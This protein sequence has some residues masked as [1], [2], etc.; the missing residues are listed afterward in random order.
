[1]SAYASAAPPPR[2][3]RWWPRVLAIVLALVA[4]LALALVGAAWWLL[5][6]SGGAQFL[7]ARAGTILGPGA[8]V[9]GV[10][11]RIGG[12]VKIRTIEID[13]PDLYVHVDDLVLDTAPLAALHGMLDVRRLTARE[14]EVRTAPSAKKAQP[15]AIPAPP[16]P[17]FLEEARVGKLRYGAISAGERA[18]A[19]P[20]AKRAARDAA[21]AKDVVLTDIVLAGSGDARR[22]TIRDAAATSE[23]GTAHLKG[24]IANARPY[25]LSLDANVAGRVQ[26]R[27]YRLAAAVRGSLR[28]LEASAHGDASGAHLE[29]RATLAPFAKQPLESLALDAKGLDLAAVRPGLPATRLDVHAALAAQG[30]GFAGPVRIANAAPGRWDQGALPFTEA[31]ARVALDPAGSAQLTGLRL[32]LAGGGSAS[33]SAS[34]A[35][36]GMK[37]DLHLADVDLAALHAKLQPTKLTGTVS[38]SGDGDAQRF[39]VALEDPRF[40]LDGRGAYRA[41]RLDLEAV[42]VRTSAG[43]VNA[44]GD[45]SF[46]GGKEFHVEGRAEHFDPSALMK[47]PAGDLN[48]AF[49]AKGA[50][51]GGISGSARVTFSPSRYAG[52]PATGHA[53]VSGD[54]KRIASSDVRLALGDARIDARGSFGREGDALDV[55][56]HAPNLATL[57]GPF[58]IPAAGSVDVQARLTGTFAEPA[59]RV[60]LA[61][62]KLSLPSDVRLDDV[63]LEAQAGT[64]AAS[65]ID[66]RLVAHG[67]AFGKGSPPPPF[68]QSVTATISGT[69]AAHTLRVDT[70]MTRESR[71]VAVLRGG[72]DERAPRLAWNGRLES[73]ALGGPGA[74]AL[75]APVP[76]AV[77]AER[78]ELGEATL[79]GDWGDVRL[80]TTRWTPATLDLQGT[81]TGVEIRT[82]AKSLRLG[83]AP[84]SNLVIAGSWSVHAAESLDASLDLHRLSGDV[85][86]GSPELDLGLTELVLR[87]EVVRGR[88]SARLDIAG[89]RIG[90]VH[91]E[92]AALLV[93]SAKGW[94]PA[95][96]APVFARLSADVPDI[97]AFGAWMGP[98]ADA[99]GRVAATL[100]VSGS[101]S[102]PRLAGEVRASDLAMREPQLGFE[103]AHGEIGLRL[104]GRSVAIERFTADAPWHA[105]QGAQDKIATA[106]GHAPGTLTASGSLDLDSRQGAIRIHLAALPVTQTPSRF[107]ALSGDAQ[108]EATKEGVLA[109]ANL[110]VDA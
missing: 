56:L 18:A 105:P 108:L 13:K 92:G 77:S 33:G 93:R 87:A 64:S 109:A 22:W 60:S 43:M 47:A 95:P 63:K 12:L 28:K 46:A 72:L 71:L 58:G 36:Q 34:I 25:R 50:M 55:T 38:L 19:D 3:R 80:Q 54:A 65:R 21:R 103:I 94:M 90:S 16:L 66:A 32:V 97:A 82:L 99:H 110:T 83:D 11:G 106:K 9:E 89:S 14:V 101:G 53:F 51:A 70:Q 76:L 8:K 98:D 59:G 35:R 31:S 17:V 73:F 37:A 44:K 30:P 52:L 96:D 68:A 57:A 74:F 23:Y 15:P 67:I 41:N 5:G 104:A 24:T 78:I 75:A 100:A 26:E 27:A 7:A 6:T 4:L 45:A 61:A 49:T 107:V 91:G 2:P 85:R 39:A 69:R 86:V 102:A 20:A 1:M 40:S 42:T 81:T 88:A 62:A 84:R 48:F 10:E 29:A 79:R